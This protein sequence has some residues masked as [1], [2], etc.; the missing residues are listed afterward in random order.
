M[1]QERQGEGKGK[2]EELTMCG[3]RGGDSSPATQTPV[4]QFEVQLPDKS[5][6]TVNSEH[7]ARVAITRAGGGTFSRR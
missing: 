3:C 2:S 6:V 4:Q 1:A 5:T 7:E